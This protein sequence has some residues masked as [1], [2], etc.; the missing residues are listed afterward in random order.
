MLTVKKNILMKSA[1][2]RF[3]ACGKRV[4]S[5]A[6]LDYRCGLRPKPCLGR[7]P[8]CSSGMSDE[9]TTLAVVLWNSLLILSLVMVMW[10]KYR[11]LRFS[12]LQD[13]GNESLLLHLIWH[14]FIYSNKTAL[15]MRPAKS[16]KRYFCLK[17]KLH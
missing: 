9:L 6:A 17:K 12:W 5:Q 4:K 10:P 8:V 1:R 11:I 14:K 7:R 15:N 16:S 2:R 3:T 13:I